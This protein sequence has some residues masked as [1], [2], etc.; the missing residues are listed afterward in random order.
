MPDRQT[1]TRTHWTM[2]A[3]QWGW[4][5]FYN[6]ELV[7]SADNPTRLIGMVPSYMQDGPA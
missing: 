4:S 3:T 1:A 7:A 6:G 2:R 5:L